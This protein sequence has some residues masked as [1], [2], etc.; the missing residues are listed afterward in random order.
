MGQHKCIIIY[1]YILFEN[2]CSDSAFQVW[3]GLR[4]R[5]GGFNWYTDST[6]VDYAYWGPGQPDNYYEDCVEISGD[7][8]GDAKMFDIVCQSKRP[9]I[10]KQVG[11]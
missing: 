5:N 6:A 2:T 9:F 7:A 11:K 8:S 10:C 4:E 1:V 3:I